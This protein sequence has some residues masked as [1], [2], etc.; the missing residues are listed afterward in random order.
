METPAA[1]PP[2][3]GPCEPPAESDSDQEAQ[4]DDA[5][6]T[7][8]V[9]SSK[10]ITIF[11]H[12]VKCTIGSETRKFDFKPFGSGESALLACEAFQKQAWATLLL[13]D[14]VK[15]KPNDRRELLK[16]AGCD[17]KYLKQHATVSSQ[18][19]ALTRRLCAG[20]VPSM[21]VK[22]LDSVFKH[23]TKGVDTSGMAILHESGTYKATFQ[24]KSHAVEKTFA[25]IA[26]AV[27]WLKS[28]ALAEKERLTDKITI[29]PTT[30]LY[31]TVLYCKGFGNTTAVLHTMRQRI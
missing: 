5:K 31:C 17:D 2:L 10:S 19:D 27:D 18:K 7:P 1:E 9:S 12:H 29:D 20:K 6:P 28:M 26:P 4:Q 22:I 13:F 8:L 21:E 25:G 16:S 24:G 23:L 14:G 3:P 30:V 11:K 15:R